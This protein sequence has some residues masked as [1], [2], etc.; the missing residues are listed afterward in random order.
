MN[1]INLDQQRSKFATR[2]DNACE[3]YAQ[4]IIVLL[5]DDEEE[6]NEEVRDLVKRCLTPAP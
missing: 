1:V 5:Y 4:E 2:Q 3:E 6:R